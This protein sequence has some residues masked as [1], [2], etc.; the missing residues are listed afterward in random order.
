MNALVTFHS[1]SQLIGKIAPAMPPEVQQLADQFS[2]QTQQTLNDFAYY[3]L[4]IACLTAVISLL[5]SSL[6]LLWHYPQLKP[7][8][9]EFHL[10]KS[11]SIQ[12]QP[13]RPVENRVAQPRRASVSVGWN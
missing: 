10:I 4:L 2:S 3:G 5:F 9:P 12:A 11:V 1:A 8:Q 7:V 13:K 6:L